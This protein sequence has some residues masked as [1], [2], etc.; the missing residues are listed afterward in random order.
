MASPRISAAARSKSPARSRVARASITNEYSRSTIQIDTSV[1]A[2]GAGSR[3]H[4]GRIGYLGVVQDTL[5]N[6]GTLQATNGG[7]LSIG[8]LTQT[9]GTVSVTASALTLFNSIANSGTITATNSSVNLNGTFTQAGLG[10]FNRPG[11]IVDLSGTL[12]GG[13]TL[14]ASTGSW[15]LHAGTVMGGTIS[16]SGGAELAFTKFRRDF[17]ER[18]H[19]QRRH[20]SR[21]GLERRAPRLAAYS[22]WTAD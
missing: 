15:F 13:L 20:G 2:D 4:R 17:Q 11:S 14:N 22:K 7:S 10:T 1:T 21:R 9:T 19:R 18:R 12:T 16:E 6:N 3:D 5:I 8:D